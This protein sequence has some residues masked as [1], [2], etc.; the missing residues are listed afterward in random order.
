MTA[1]Q[2]IDNRRTDDA[3]IVTF[4]YRYEWIES[5]LY[6]TRK[7][8]YDVPLALMDYPVESINV[9]DDITIIEI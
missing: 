1:Q 7:T 3:I 5:V 9:V 2:A 4:T 8:P 6:D